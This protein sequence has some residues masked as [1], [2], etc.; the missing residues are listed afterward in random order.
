MIPPIS[1]K[2]TCNTRYGFRISVYLQIT[3]ETD[4]RAERSINLNYGCLSQIC[5]LAAGAHPE[6]H[7]PSF[8]DQPLFLNVTQNNRDP[9]H[10]KGIPIPFDF[11]RC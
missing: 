3:I 11:N 10:D 8:I 7:L 5:M 6:D 9:M 2:L 4:D 1:L